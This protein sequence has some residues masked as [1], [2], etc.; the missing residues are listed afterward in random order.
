MVAVVNEDVFLSDNGKEA[1]LIELWP[2]NQCFYGTTSDEYKDQSKISQAYQCL[3]EFWSK[4][5]ERSQIPV[6]VVFRFLP[7]HVV[8]Q[9]PYV[10][11]FFAKYAE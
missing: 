11:A 9:S 7:K 6:S 8:A 3:F 1:N 10:F 4:S 2:Q 5:A